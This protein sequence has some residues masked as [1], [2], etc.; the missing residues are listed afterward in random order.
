MWL[1]LYNAGTPKQLPVPSL[2]GSRLGIAQRYVW[3]LTMMVK[4]LMRD[5]SLPVHDGPQDWWLQ[6]LVRQGLNVRH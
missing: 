5:Y 2:Q 6:H 4:I 1:T 3:N